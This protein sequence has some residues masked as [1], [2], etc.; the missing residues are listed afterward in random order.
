MNKKQLN[1]IEAELLNIAMLNE[2]L[3]YALAYAEDKGLILES[4]S[5]TARKM[6]KKLEKCLNYF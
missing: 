1:K 3:M 6:Q 2:I 4:G 5:Y